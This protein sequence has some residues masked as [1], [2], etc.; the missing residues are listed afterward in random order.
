MQRCKR[1]AERDY[2][3]TA[4]QVLAEGRATS[5]MWSRR[6]YRLPEGFLE[7][8]PSHRAYL[9]GKSEIGLIFTIPAND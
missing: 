9:I 7:H 5:V 3:A 4:N 2:D 1:G 6:F 8:V